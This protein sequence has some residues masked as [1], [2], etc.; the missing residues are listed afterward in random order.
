MNGNDIIIIVND[1]AIAACKASTIRINADV[2]E[3]A[4]VLSGTY[5]EYTTGRKSWAIDNSVFISELPSLLNVGTIVN[6]KI[7]GG[8][9]TLTGSGIITSRDINAQRGSL[10]SGSISIQGTGPLTQ[11]TT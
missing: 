1:Q 8:G 9:S 6:V 10:A 4:G 7:S 11:V 5:R 3:I 2:I